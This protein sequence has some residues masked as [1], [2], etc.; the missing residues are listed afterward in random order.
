[1]ENFLKTTKET[2]TVVVSNSTRDRWFILV[3]DA[4][5]HA[6][7]EHRRKLYEQVKYRLPTIQLEENSTLPARITAQKPP[8]NPTGQRLIA[9]DPAED[10]DMFN[11]LT[12]LNYAIVASI[13]KMAAP[14]AKRRMLSESASHTARD[15]SPQPPVQENN[16]E[17]PCEFQ[18]KFRQL[19]ETGNRQPRKEKT[20][21]KA[22]PTM[23]KLMTRI[24]KVGD[25]ITR[26]KERLDAGIP[27]SIIAP[28]PI[29]VPETRNFTEHWY[30]D[31]NR[32]LM[33]T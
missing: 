5:F 6:T 19:T 27:S 22:V 21:I 12:G 14:G 1:M 11:M 10:D 16:D 7:P 26:E 28:P 17:K 3:D 32:I 4:T 18:L 20:N 30:T 15:D 9:L 31:T 13:R 24:I 8:T 23:S 25:A 33:A 29:R 2:A